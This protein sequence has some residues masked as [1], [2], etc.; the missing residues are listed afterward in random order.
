MIEL[1]QRIIFGFVYLTL[2]A[3]GLLAPYL[4]SRG[5]L[6]LRNGNRDRLV[7]IRLP[8]RPSRSSGRTA[9]FQKRGWTNTWLPGNVR[10]RRI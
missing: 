1:R 10:G 3:Y 9:A 8:P 2:A 5:V 7:S 4:I 6:D